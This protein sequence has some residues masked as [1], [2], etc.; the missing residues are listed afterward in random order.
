MD[1]KKVFRGISSKLSHD[2]AISAEINHLGNKGTYRESALKDF[3]GEARLPKR[4]GIGSGEIIG[5]TRNVSK[6]SDLIIYDQLDGMSFMYSE[7]IQIY[8]IESVFG[9][10]EVK[11]CLSKTELLASLENIKSVKS[12]YTE[13]SMTKTVNSMLSITSRRPQ[14]FGIIFAYSLSDNSLGSLLK[15]LN[16]WEAKNEKKHW[17]NLVVILGEGILYHFG[18]GFKNMSLFTNNEI[19]KALGASYLAYA[20]DTLFHFYS[21]LID[22]CSSTSIGP[23]NLQHY[24]N[25]AEQMGNYVIRN[26]DQFQRFSDPHVYRLKHEFIEHLVQT[27]HQ[28][29]PI[30]LKD[31]YLKQFGQI[32]ADMDDEYLNQEVFHYDPNCLPG[33]HQVENS[34]DIS[35]QGAFVTTEM[36]LPTCSLEIN[37]EIY[38]FPLSYINEND[39]EV[40]PG[41]MIKDL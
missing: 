28:I 16:E 20:N 38:I 14:P 1:L 6:Q 8:P 5:P 9:V 10:I 13:E 36:L 3:L 4:F 22:L 40:V 41:K 30:K 25:P 39:L 23:V 33:I 27:C 11:S 31:L 2:F 29:G 34:L 7:S 17:P 26:H 37:R 18:E 12:L 21:I 19:T 32:P 15:N 35:D 24:F